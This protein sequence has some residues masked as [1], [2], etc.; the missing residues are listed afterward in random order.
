MLRGSTTTVQSSAPDG[1]SEPLVVWC[2]RIRPVPARSEAWQCAWAL[3][4]GAVPWQEGV[5]VLGLVDLEIAAF[6]VRGLEGD[7][8]TL[9]PWCFLGIGQMHRC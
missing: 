6:A 5:D 2:D 3:G 9:A 7:D 8:A 1:L 4:L